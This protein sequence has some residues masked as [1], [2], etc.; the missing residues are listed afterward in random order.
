[1]AIVN[2]F[3][4]LVLL[5]ALTALLMWFGSLFGRIGLIIGLLIAIS[6]NVGSYWFSDKLVLKMYKAKEIN[7]N[8]N[9][10][11]MIEGVAVSANL[12]MPKVYII[13]SEQPNA[14]A[15]GRNPNHSAV[16]FSKGILQL[17]NDDELIGVAAHELAHI[18]NR[19]TL[20]TTIAA[21]IGGVITYMANVAQWAMI[22]GGSQSEDGQHLVS[23]I[24]MIIVAPI[25]ATII[26]LAI[27]RSREY[28]ADA[29]GA[30]FI[31]SS[32]GLASALEKLQNNSTPMNLGNKTTSSLFIKNPLKSSGWSAMF[33]THPPMNKR[34]EKL[35]NMQL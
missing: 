33:S 27:S 24:F 9:L 28:L 2:Q 34:I 22:F 25:A 12:P 10:Y 18:K 1:M 20:I 32:A 6:I 23:M 17:L 7:S 19:D 30:K 26:Q 29:K 13:P 35:N 21:T 15:T 5:S 14:F 16:A 11:K 8:E 4:T 31:G 3:K